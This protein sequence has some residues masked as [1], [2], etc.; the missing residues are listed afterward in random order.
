MTTYTF[1]PPAASTNPPV[2]PEGDPA[3][4]VGAFRLRR[5]YSSMPAGIN[6]Y[7]YKAG[8]PSAMAFGQVSEVDPITVYASG[9]PISTGWE[10]IQHVLWGGSDNQ[11]VTAAEAALLTAQGYTVL[12]DG[13]PPPPPSA[14]VIS[15]ISPSSGIATTTVT[16]TGSDFTG[17][18]SVLVDGTSA[19]FVVVNS[20]R[21]TF[22]APTHVDAAVGVTVTTPSGTSNSATFTYSTPVPGAAPVISSV[23]PSSGASLSAVALTGTGLTGATSVTFGG[24]AQSYVVANDTSITIASV[25][26]H[27][28]GAV[29]VLDTTSN[30]TSNSGSFTYTTAVPGDPH[31]GSD[32]LQ[33]DGVSFILQEDGVSTIQQES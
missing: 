14:P 1:T 29:A 25:T 32:I 13:A 24:A 18:T 6:V 9:V 10:D 17:A 16:L 26:T 21:L 19:T 20:S 23:T 27:A 11:V 31:P 12:S 8:S 3:Q 28:D 30:G 2:L 15:T 5:F 7:I 22:T 33:E 4:T